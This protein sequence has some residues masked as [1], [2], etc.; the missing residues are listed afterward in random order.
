MGI[1]RY[2]E[3][4][5]NILKR[6]FNNEENTEIA[7]LN[8]IANTINFDSIQLDEKGIE[9][10]INSF[11][12]IF[13]HLTTG[14]W[15][16]EEPHGDLLYASKGFEE[17]LNLPLKTIYE[18]PS[19]RYRMVHPMHKK[20]VATNFELV[21]KGKTVQ[22]LYPITD[23]KEQKKWLLEQIVPRVN[24]NGIVSQV[25]GMITDVT[26]EVDIEEKLNFLANYDSLTK[27]PNQKSLFEKLDQDCREGADFALLYFD[28]DRFHVINNS[29]GYQIGDE[30][31]KKIALRLSDLT[32]EEG[33]LARLNSNDFIMIVKKYRDEKEIYQ[34]AEKILGTFEK[35]I[36]IQDYVL[37][38]TT[39]IGI[40]FFP[41]EGERRLTLLE[42]AHTALYQA[43]RQGKN[44]YHLF[45]HSRDI[46][47][48]KKYVL[49]RDMRLALLNDEF[50]LY[51]QPQVEPSKGFVVGAE[52]LI[53]WQHPEWGDIS[54][55]EFIPLAEENHMVNQI[56]DWE[57]EKVCAILHEWKR[58][59]YRLY[60]ISINVSPI[61]FMKKGL[62]EFV[63]AQLEKYDVKPQYLELEI[64]E[65]SLL[66][67][68]QTVLTILKELKAL[69]VKVAVDD[70]G[71]GYSSLDYLRKIKPDTI[72]IDKTF[73][74][75]IKSESEVDKG[76]IAS[77][78]FLGKRLEMKVVAEG[79][80]DKEQLDFLKHNECDMIQGFLFSEPVPQEKFE[81]IIQVGYLK[82]VQRTK[83]KSSL[84]ENR[85]F[86]RFELPL[87]IH[88]KMTIAEVNDQVVQVGSTPVL[89]ENLSLGGIKVLSNLKLPV[90]S[91]MKFKFEFKVLNEVI[92]VFGK[93]RWI[94][95]E[96]QDVYSY[97]VIFNLNR[98]LEDNLSRLINRMTTL[99]ITN[100]P[101]PNTEF[102]Y[103]QVAQFFNKS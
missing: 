61:R 30:A 6:L 34:L 88:G 5:L 72:K 100:Q 15:M 89:I 69:G 2:K 43:K 70:F 20:E 8:K 74:N 84:R 40:T 80:E 99:R 96:L 45:S 11:Q 38:I 50:T 86:Y 7:E 102:I 51:F 67:T 16:R 79:V 76:V 13:D 97:G 83:K 62:V 59:G 94:E 77:I 41:E 27:L 63:K 49:D 39:S 90:N 64:T 47:S 42:N 22:M 75:N 78:L 56:I 46:P 101:I 82:A 28:I 73:I 85:K 14:I 57:I 21:A 58:K 1:L 33:Y 68:D 26:H 65:S 37:H 24:E 60:P 3:P 9:S 44:T 25:F 35:S 71:T 29:L 17:I 19:L 55:G 31:L 36:T 66:K 54:P 98:S 87:Y 23:G 18:T 103:D 92:E 32:P 81:K 4:K 10:E 95:D 12:Y 48:Y 53:R 52:V 93:L 91:N